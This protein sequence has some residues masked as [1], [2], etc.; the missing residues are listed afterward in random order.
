MARLY[1]QDSSRQA[2]GDWG[3]VDRKTLN[4]TLTNAAFRLESN[5][6]SD[7]LDG[8]NS[9]YILKVTERKS[10]YTKPIGE[11]RPELEK[12]LFSDERARKQE[13]WIAGLRA[14]AFIKTF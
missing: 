6:I 7:V 5:K 9:Y 12:K 13:Q 1:S 8:G 3:W 4:E 11:V 2:G 14:K 10:A